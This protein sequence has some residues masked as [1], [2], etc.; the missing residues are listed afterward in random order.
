MPNFRCLGFLDTFDAVAQLHRLQSGRADTFLLDESWR[1][2]RSLVARARKLIPR[3]EELRITA[4]VQR[5]APGGPSAWRIADGGFFEFRIPLVT[6]PGVVEHRGPESVSM[7]IG[8]LWWCNG[9][10]WRCETNWGQHPSYHMVI[11]AEPPAADLPVGAI[12]DT[13][14]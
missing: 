8:S 5:R 1:S 10:T 6:N 14:G 12:V 2:G 4:E 13:V 9:E 7:G 3:G 11:H